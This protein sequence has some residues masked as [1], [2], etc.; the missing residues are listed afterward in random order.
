MDAT[1]AKGPNIANTISHN[2]GL[3]LNSGVPSGGPTQTAQAAGN[4]LAEKSF[5]IF[6]SA[7]GPQR[8]FYYWEGTQDGTFAR[9]SGGTSYDRPSLFRRLRPGPRRPRE[10]LFQPALYAQPANELSG[11]AKR[12]GRNTLAG[13]A[14]VGACRCSR[15][16]VGQR[17]PGSAMVSFCGLGE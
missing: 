14:L 12:M 13:E 17:V 15:H 9:S 6:L 16:R 10:E 8:R 2:C 4:Q 7:L 11:L 1:W 3:A 5:F